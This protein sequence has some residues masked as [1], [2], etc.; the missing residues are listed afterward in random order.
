MDDS[1][2]LR[3]KFYGCIAGA[4]I[5]SAMGAAVEGWNYQMIEEEY[6]TLDELL[7]Y[8]HYNN[9]CPAP[10]KTVSRDRN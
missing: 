6:G 4:H 8:E 7:P 10:P 2:S 3:D 9:G 5:G 1:V